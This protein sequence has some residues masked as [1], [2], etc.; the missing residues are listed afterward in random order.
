MLSQRQFKIMK[1]TAIPMP[2]RHQLLQWLLD[3]CHQRINSIMHQQL[4]A[5][6]SANN[7]IIFSFLQ[8][9]NILPKNIEIDQDNSKIHNLT[10]S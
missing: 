10:P 3:F 6:T 5:Y 1:K 9:T 4:L 2:Q 8:A 7:G